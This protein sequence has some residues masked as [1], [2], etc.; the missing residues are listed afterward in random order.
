MGHILPDFL[1]FVSRDSHRGNQHHN[2]YGQPYQPHTQE[3]IKLIWL[4]K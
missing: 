2:G 4:Q 1:G 3:M